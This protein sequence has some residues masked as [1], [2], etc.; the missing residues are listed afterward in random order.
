[1]NKFQ[2]R[3]TKM[4]SHNANAVVLGKGFGFLEHILK[5]FGT[6]FLIDDT[7]PENRGKNLVYMANHLSLPPA[8]DVSAIFLDRNKVNVLGTVGSVLNRCNCAII[9]EGEEIIP[10]DQS[11]LL[12]STGFRAI[13]QNGLFHTWKRTK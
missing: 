5:S 7:R 13:D 6:V 11:Q 8:L 9:I 3:I 12:Y 4:L 10:R 1:M 2:K